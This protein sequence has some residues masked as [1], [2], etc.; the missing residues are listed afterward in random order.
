MRTEMSIW[1]MGAISMTI[2]YTKFKFDGHFISFHSIPDNDIATN[3][4]A[5]HD[6][7]V[8]VAC[9]KH[10]NEKFIGIWMNA[11][12]NFF[13]MIELPGES[14]WWTGPL[15]SYQCW[16]MRFVLT[17]YSSVNG[18][19]SL[20][21]INGTACTLWKPPVNLLKSQQLMWRPSGSKWNQW[22]LIFKLVG[23]PE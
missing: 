21:A 10:C 9:A 17:N 7:T 16:V 6:N 22:Y 11:E 20:V 18:Y 13:R 19:V 5:C 12:W 3:V 14:L 23:V 8:V 4:C 2:F 15:I 1:Q